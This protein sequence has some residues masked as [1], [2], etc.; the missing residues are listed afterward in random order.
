MLCFILGG[1]TRYR[2]PA[3][4]L[5][6]LALLASLVAL[7]HSVFRIAGLAVLSYRRL[8]RRTARASTRLA[9][10]PSTGEHRRNRRSGEP[11]VLTSG[12]SVRSCEAYRNTTQEC[13]MRQAGYTVAGQQFVMGFF[14][15]VMAP[16]APAR[17]KVQVFGY[18]TAYHLSNRNECS[19]IG[20]PARY[21]Q[22]RTT[23]RLRPDGSSWLGSFHIHSTHPS[24][25]A[26]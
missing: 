4:L 1:S 22:C 21:D 3:K 6:L 14:G 7:R 8:L 26:T 9:L 24:P 23:D 11:H 17:S 12:G 15:Q 20:I 16:V 5:A 2:F 25:F 18:K 13:D 10:D 19:F